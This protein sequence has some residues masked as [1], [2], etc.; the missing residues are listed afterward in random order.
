M[1]A[2]IKLTNSETGETIDIPAEKA[3]QTGPE[4]TVDP[5]QYVSV[6]DPTTGVVT[7][8]PALEYV[9]SRSQAPTTTQDIESRRADVIKY[10]TGWAPIQTAAESAVSGATLG[11][12]DL[13]A[14]AVA[15]NY[16]AETQKREQYNPNAALAGEITGIV[17]PAL[18]LIRLLRRWRTKKMPLRSAKKVTQI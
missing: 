7:E 18:L 9:N 12:S 11:L 1:V 6:I 8:T 3:W 14:S 4:W 2:N 16:Y 5:N 17:A 15:P 10:G 13:A